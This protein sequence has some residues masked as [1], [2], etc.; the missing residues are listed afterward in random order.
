MIPLRDHNPTSRPAIV[1]PSLVA[2]NIGMFL[3]FQPT[4]RT[5]GTDALE[6]EIV[7]SN[8][9]AC[10]ASIP[11]EITR[12][13]LVLDGALRGE[14]TSRTGQIIAQAED[15]FARTRGA[16]FATPCR[17]K[18]VWLSIITS[19]FM[20]GGFLHIAGNML[21]LWVFGNNIEDR[22]G[23]LRFILFYLLAG[24]AATYA[25]AAVNPSSV[26]PLIGASGAV[27]G[28]LGAYL[29]LYPRARVTTLVIFFFI[30]AVEVP[31]VLLLGAWFV[32]QL[33]Q[34]VGSVAGDAGGVAYFAHIGGFIAGVLLLGIFRLRRAARPR[35]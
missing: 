22:L 30:T 19:M 35:W 33:F 4:L 20:H 5:A 10:H 18:N 34:G 9:T 21:F 28:V 25:Q 15:G 31:A 6:R 12:G 2:I 1:V 11:Y 29:V 32:L 3:F 23:R 26:I 17:D 8:F 14:V 13:E 27:A 24:A 7:Q 16:G